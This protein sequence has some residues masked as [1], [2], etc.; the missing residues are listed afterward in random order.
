[1]KEDFAKYLFERLSVE[2]LSVIIDS[3]T[4]KPQEKEIL[5]YCYIKYK[6]VR[7]W[8]KCAAYDLSVDVKTVSRRYKK[9][10]KESA[11]PLVLF[12]SQRLNCP[13]KEK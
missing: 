8:Q 2:T 9:A 3:L 12:V 13:F 11:N 10:L 5:K 6:G 1:M 7:G 4:I